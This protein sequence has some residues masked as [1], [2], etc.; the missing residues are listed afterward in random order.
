MKI[1]QRGNKQLR[2]S[3]DQLDNY[4]AKGYVEIDPKTGKS[5]AKKPADEVKALKK[6]NADLK[7]ANK[8]LTEKL[9]V[10]TNAQE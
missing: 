3:D 6:E 10:L 9:A 5:I 8:E 7:K 1:V 4:A 2:I